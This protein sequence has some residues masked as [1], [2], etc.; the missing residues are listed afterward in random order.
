MCNLRMRVPMFV[1]VL[2]HNLEGYDSHL[3]VKSLGLEEGDIRCIPK[4]DEK[5]ISFSKNI[6]M[7]TIFMESGK[8]KVVCLE[9]RF[10]DSLKFTLKSLDSLVKTLGE[11]QFETLTSQMPKESLDLLKRKGVFPYKYMTDFS[12]LGVKS[13]PPKEAFYSQLNDNH[14]GDHHAKKVWKT[15]NCETMRDY[16]NLYL[17]TDVLLLADVMTEFRKTCKKTYGLEALHYYTSLGLAW[18]AMLKITEVEIDM[19]LM[20]ESGIRGGIS[21][22]TKRYARANNKCLSDYDEDQMSVYIPYLDTNNLYGWAMR[23]K[24]PVKDFRWM[25]EDELKNWESKPRVL[26]V[27]LE[28][29]KEL[30]DFHNEYPLAPERLQ[31]DKVNKLVPNLYDKKKYVLHYENLKLYLRLGLR[32]TKIHRGIT[33]AEEDFMKKYIDLNT[34]LR[35]KGTTDFEKMLGIGSM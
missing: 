14:I 18:D 33:F 7:E 13:L 10:I 16:H 12:K 23:H 26:E 22:I 19:Y 27:D 21:T 4:T 6:P 2:F 28:Y 8:E 5:Y 35:T 34:E 1:P 31:I 25:S 15:F 24:L 9:M 32:L 20:V 3:F 11:D 30:H 29:P 17:K